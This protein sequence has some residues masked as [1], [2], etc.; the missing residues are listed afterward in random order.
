MRTTVVILLVAAFAGTAF[1]EDDA[2]VQFFESRIR[3]ILADNCYACHSHAA[4]KL[5][6]SLYLDSRAGVLKGGESGPAL[7]PGAPEKSRLIESIGYKNV[8]LQ[9]P[10]K[11]KLGDRQI[12]DLTAWVKMGA[13]WAHGHDGRRRGETGRVQPRTAEGEA[14]GV[15]TG[16]TAGAARG[17]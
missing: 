8:D 14:L 15:A 10:P 1:A 6:A 7:V 11:D 4:K 12:A 5:K 2:G 3:P 17:S 9:M 13:P 16:R